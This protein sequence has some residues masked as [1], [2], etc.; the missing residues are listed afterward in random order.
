MYFILYLQ[1]LSIGRKG[2]LKIFGKFAGKHLWHNVFFIKVTD[3]VP[4]I[5]GI[6]EQKYKEM[7]FVTPWSFY[8][9]RRS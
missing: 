7:Y 9:E 4:L 8:L 1:E 2:V 5:V 6:Y 3:N